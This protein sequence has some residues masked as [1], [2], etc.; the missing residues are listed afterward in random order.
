MALFLDTFI[1]RIDRKGRVSVPATFRASLANQSFQGIVAF[2]SFKLPALQCAGLDWMEELNANLGA[3][4]LFSDSHDDMTATIFAGAKQLPFDG[5]GRIMLPATL[6]QHAG[7]ADTAAFVG[8]GRSFEIWQPEAF[9]L[10]RISARQRALD[11]RRTLPQRPDG[12]R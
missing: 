8:R 5:E 4:D 9:E 10:Y 3:V 7:I 11:T 2:A 6:A 1:N 12:G